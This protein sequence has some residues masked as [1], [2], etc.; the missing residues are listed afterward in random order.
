MCYMGIEMNLSCNLTG[1]QRQSTLKCVFFN[2]I[3]FHHSGPHHTQAY[4][5]WGQSTAAYSC[6]GGKIA[7]NRPGRRSP[8]V[9]LQFH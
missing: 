9:S 8:G 5:H 4:P 1:V 2:F 7:I 6:K 3:S